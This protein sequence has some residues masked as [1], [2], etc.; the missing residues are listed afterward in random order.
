MDK[1]DT[2]LKELSDYASQVS[3]EK[4]DMFLLK[5][6]EPSGLITIEKTIGSTIFI[7]TT[8]AGRKRRSEIL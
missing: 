6:M 2:I 5:K 1:I 7:I 8:P 3:K 4:Y